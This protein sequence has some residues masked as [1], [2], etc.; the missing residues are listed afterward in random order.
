MSKLI[1]RIAASTGANMYAQATTIGIQLLSLPLFLSRWGLETYG[2]WLIISAIPAYI[3]M[4]DVGMVSAAGNRMT[5]L[6]GNKDQAGASAVF[7]SATAFM[8]IVCLS[9]A[10]VAALIIQFLPVDY[11]PSADSRLALQALVLAVLFALFGGLPEAVYRA[12]HRYAFGTFVSNTIRLCEWAGGLAGLWLYGSFVAVAIGMLIARVIGTLAMIIN[13]R[14]DSPEFEWGFAKATVQ[15]I[16]DT[17]GPA[18][19]FMAFPL[20]NAIAFQGVTLVVAATLGPAA[21]AIFNTYRTIARVTVQATATFGHALWPEFS[22]LFGAGDFQLLSTIY[23]RA[24]VMGIVTSALTGV[25]VYVVAPYVLGA[26]SKGK[27][28]FMPDLMVMAML[29]ATIAG[30]WHVCRVLLLATNKHGHL[31]WQ[32]LVVSGL[33]LPAAWALCGNYG[34]VGAMGAMAAGEFIMLIV[35]TASSH[36]L[37]VSPP[38]LVEGGVQL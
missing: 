9:V 27:I 13:V 25:A 16:R 32:Y 1:R 18:I 4:A 20:G 6:V 3:S 30:C 7:Q 33:T 23:K 14:R 36:R 12:T 28:D 8:S 35:C 22:R 19:A 10:V 5:M 37:L 29:Y 38:A 21:T 2:Q 31:A 24:Y 34:L 17:A 15:E 11:L 26:W